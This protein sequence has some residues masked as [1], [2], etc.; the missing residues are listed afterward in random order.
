MSRLTL[1]MIVKNEAKQIERCL[2]SCIDY[3]DYWIIVDT[4]SNDGTQDLIRE[5]LSAIPGKLY[6]RPWVNFGVNR[7]QLLQIY[8]DTFDLNDERAFALLLDADQVLQVH[9]RGFKSKIPPGHQYFVNVT[10]SGSTEYRMPYLL[11]MT[12]SYKYVGATHEFLTTEDLAERVMYDEISIFHYGDGGSKKNKLQR[13]RVL[14]LDEIKQ[15]PM[16]SRA[17]FYLAQTLNDLGDRHGA[18]VHYNFALQHANWIEEKYISALRMGHIFANKGDIANALLLYNKAIDVSPGRS[19]AYYYV[20]KMLNNQ[21]SHTLAAIILSRG[22]E[23]SSSKDILFV[24]RW[25]ENFG[26]RLEFGVA[27]W[28]LKNFEVAKREFK[29]L[30]A[31]SDLPN[32]TRE[33]VE[34]NL[35]LCE[36]S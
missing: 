32:S 8:Q 27:Q 25:I 12:R 28:W 10:S 3:I 1:L 30:L 23:N 22:L 9:D 18:L 29:T 5:V 24:E 11:R 16:N 20:G 35:A 14:L 21:F 6:E 17:H 36:P 15:E 2:R 33:L 13:D 19:E 7:S 31:I 34:R 4:G 26:M